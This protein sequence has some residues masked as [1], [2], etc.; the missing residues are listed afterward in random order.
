[1]TRNHLL[2]L[3]ATGARAVAWFHTL[4]AEYLR[5][6]LSWSLRPKWRNKRALR[7]AMWQGMT[8]FLRGR[9]GSTYRVR[10]PVLRGHEQAV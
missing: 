5:T 2:F 9:F 10:W 8:D 6:W 4:V 3:Q 7:E 1:M